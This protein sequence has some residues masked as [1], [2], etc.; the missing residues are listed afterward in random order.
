MRVEIAASTKV[1]YEIPTDD[2][3]MFSGTVAGICYLPDTI[4]SLRGEPEERTI[5][6]YKGNLA[7]MHHSVFSHV[8][9]NLLLTNVPKIL[10]MVLNNEKLYTTSEKSARYTQ[11]APSAEERELYEKWIGLFQRRVIEEYGF[12]E[13]YALKLAQENAR[14]LISVFTPATTMMYTVNLQ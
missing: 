5:S 4:E 7:S 12:K 1:G 2:A 10:A 3:L 13:K 8:T 9:Y 6:R 14:Y 11:M